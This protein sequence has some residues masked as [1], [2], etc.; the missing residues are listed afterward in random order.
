MGR[1]SRKPPVNTEKRRDWLKRYEDGQ[2]PPE[3]AETDHYDVRTV[4]QQIELAKQEREAREAKVL[5]LRNAWEKHYDDFRK[6]AETLNSQ[7][8][9]SGGITLSNDQELIQAA[10]RQHLP[11]S[12]I[13]DY[14]HKLPELKSNS[15]Q[16]IHDIE[17]LM[18]DAA[19]THTR[20]KQIIGAYPTSAFGSIAG[21]LAGQ[22]QHWAG[23]KEPPALK[24]SL[25]VDTS[26][27]EPYD[28][29]LGPA[30]IGKVDKKHKEEYDRILK[31]I[32]SGYESRLRESEVYGKFE[33]NTAEITRL[34]RKLR[35]ELAI[36]RFK[37]IVPGHCDY[38]P[39]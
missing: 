28:I 6:L 8:S 12:Y 3:I 24:E 32:L 33:A 4:R 22:A 23:G 25:R 16:L 2:S 27:K 39:I 35:D 7:I 10:L 29:H 17:K 15:D 26:G 20:L 14:L 37:R 18:K 1:R 30:L 13:W 38:C 11:R 31:D 19:I 36:I 9:G 21:A 5:V 34:S